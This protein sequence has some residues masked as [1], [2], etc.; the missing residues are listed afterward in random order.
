MLSILL[1]KVR[2]LVLKNHP[3][4]FSKEAPPTLYLQLNHSPSLR[5]EDYKLDAWTRQLYSK[6]IKVPALKK[7]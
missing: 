6:L 3:D 7:W 2:Q 4:E 5:G 1:P